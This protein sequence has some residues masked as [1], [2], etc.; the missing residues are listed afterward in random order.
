MSIAR[1]DNFRLTL[2]AALRLRDST[3]F[4]PSAPPAAAATK[5]RPK[6]YLDVK[7][8]VEVVWWILIVA[9]LL[10]DLTCHLHGCRD[11]RAVCFASGLS[12][13]LLP[14]DAARSASQT[15]R[16]SRACIRTVVA[17][18]DDF[19]LNWAA[20]LRL[21]DFTH[22]VPLAPP[23]AGSP[24]HSNRNLQLTHGLPVRS[25]TGHINCVNLRLSSGNQ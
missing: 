23:V 24:P 20:A 1:S 13:A 9:R 18:C 17:K 12:V 2:V 19:R 10:M 7:F 11:H 4:A 21:R 3:N 6:L 15:A 25:N 14:F 5:V 16:S 22:F 8:S